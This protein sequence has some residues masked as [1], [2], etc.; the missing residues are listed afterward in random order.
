MTTL[1]AIGVFRPSPQK[2]ALIRSMIRQA[3]DE[4]S[5][6]EVVQALSAYP[7]DALER[8]H[9]Y[10][11]RLE[12]YDQD[13]EVPNY[14]PTLPHPFV[15]GAYN[16]AANVLGF[17]EAD[18]SAFVLLHEFAHALD[19]SMGEA[20][21]E[22]AWKE[23]HLTACETGE[24]VRRYARVNSSEYFAENTTAY[25]IADDA[26]VPLVKKGLAEEIGTEGMTRREYMMMHI[27]YSNT[28]LKLADENGYELVAETLA[29]L[30]ELP[31]PSQKP[32]MNEAQY[33]EFIIQDQKAKSNPLSRV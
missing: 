27:N 5:V 4:E 32:A 10:G 30:D 6:Q 12:V 1:P 19:A 16:T 23:A 25:L 2:E 28:R 8:V 18:L 26:L 20:S 21:E 31:P 14:M 3:P 22:A 7:I 29:E 13:Q 15:V 24:V 33:S 11:T 9:D 17:E